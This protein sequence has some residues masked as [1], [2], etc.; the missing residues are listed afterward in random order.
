MS[1][2]D[3]IPVSKLAKTFIKIRDARSTLKKEYEAK[4]KE[5]VE[6]QDQIKTALLD[7]CEENDVESVR[8]DEGTFFRSVRNRYWTSDWESMH[9]FI[10]EHKSPELLEKRLNQTAMREY[11]EE[12]PEDYP[13]GLNVDAVYTITVRKPTK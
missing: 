10:I 12:N 13:K 9:K 2:P 6:A 11:L 3:N 1:S 8:T 4:D 5:L 7:Y